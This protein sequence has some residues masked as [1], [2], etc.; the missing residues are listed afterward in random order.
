MTT[1]LRGR[2][3]EQI[4]ATMTPNGIV[5]GF[6]ILVVAI[7]VTLTGG[8][9]ADEGVL[10]GTLRSAADIGGQWMRIALHQ[11]LGHTLPCGG[12]IIR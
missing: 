11:V 9:V 1:S 3:K 7:E 5:I 6:A 4:T 10:L 12:I 2:V 8:S